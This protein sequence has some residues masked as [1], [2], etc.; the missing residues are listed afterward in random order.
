M[1]G[2]GAEAYKES[3]EE[4]AERY[5][6]SKRNLFGLNSFFLVLFILIFL[7]PMGVTKTIIAIIVLLVLYGF[8]RIYALN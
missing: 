7:I 2:I 1:S 4:D 5:K 3:L 6:H 8:V